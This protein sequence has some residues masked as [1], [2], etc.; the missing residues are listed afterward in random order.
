MTIVYTETCCDCNGS[1]MVDCSYCF[2]SG[3]SIGGGQCEYCYG[4]GDEECS[5]C[6]GSG[7][8]DVNGDDVLDIDP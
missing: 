2:G 4:E 8:V 5:K 7:S 1:G 3:Y 6:G